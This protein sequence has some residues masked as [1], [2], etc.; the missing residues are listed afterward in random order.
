MIE[1][2]V[3][4]DSLKQILTLYTKKDSKSENENYRPVSILP[5]LSKISG[6]ACMHRRTSIL[7][8]FF[9]NT[10]L[11]LERGTVHNNVNLLWLKNGERL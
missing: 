7:T 10:S 4:P 2:S 5:N 6:A 8:L 1:N 11:D 9:L 3:F